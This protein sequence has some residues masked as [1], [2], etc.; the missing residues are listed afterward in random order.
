MSGSTGTSFRGQPQSVDVA[1]RILF[2]NH[3]KIKL[4]FGDIRTSNLYLDLVTQTVTCPCFAANQTIVL[5]I[6]LVI[7]IRQVANR[8]KVFAFGFI[9]LNI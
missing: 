7:V 2:I 9:K 4:F 1:W 8:N 3:N 6:K 5:G